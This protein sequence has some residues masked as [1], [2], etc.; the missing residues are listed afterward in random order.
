MQNFLWAFA[1]SIFIHFL[2]LISF[3]DIQIDNQKPKYNNTNKTK[4]TYIKLA[5][6]KQEK[7]KPIKQEIKK[8]IKK[9]S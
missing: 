9:N 3:N 1:I 5:T 4:Y 7:I 2:L 8:I 6:L